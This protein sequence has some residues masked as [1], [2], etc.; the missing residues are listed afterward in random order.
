MRK[1]GKIEDPVGRE[2]GLRVAERIARADVAKS[3]WVRDSGDDR[4]SEKDGPKQT[5]TQTFHG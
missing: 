3:P 2:Q 1:P 4:V 5:R